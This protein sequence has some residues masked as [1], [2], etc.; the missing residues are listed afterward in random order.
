[1]TS[2]ARNDKSAFLCALRQK[3]PRWKIYSEPAD[4]CR[5]NGTG[6]ITTKSGRTQPCLCVCIEGDDDSRLGFCRAVG[7]A[8][9]EINRAQQRRE[10]E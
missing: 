9:R 3:H 5:C 2:N 10:D 6:E 4:G 7:N 1:M 8:A